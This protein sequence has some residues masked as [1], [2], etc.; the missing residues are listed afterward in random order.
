MLLFF[1]FLFLPFR[2]P[3]FLLLLWFL[4]W[5][6]ESERGVSFLEFEVFILKHEQ[7]CGFNGV[8]YNK[9]KCMILKNPH[10]I[11]VKKFVYIFFSKNPGEDGI[12][13]RT[14]VHVVDVKVFLSSSS[15]C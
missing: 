13:R 12:S 3:F 6:G 4:L 8:L 14:S 9:K 10:K 7:I 15:A 5:R 1:L 2:L 11:K